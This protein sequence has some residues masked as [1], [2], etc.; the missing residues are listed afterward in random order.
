MLFAM[1]H[2]IVVLSLAKSVK[3][4]LYVCIVVRFSDTILLQINVCN[5]IIHL[6]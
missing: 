2:V 4:N 1:L 3:H 6:L 5:V